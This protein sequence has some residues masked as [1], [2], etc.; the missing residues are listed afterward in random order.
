MRDVFL[1]F[2]ELLHRDALA[3]FRHEQLCDF[4]SGRV[5]L[6]KSPEPHPVIAGGPDADRDDDRDESDSDRDW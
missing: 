6:R 2:V 5:Q 4:A 3:A 1:D